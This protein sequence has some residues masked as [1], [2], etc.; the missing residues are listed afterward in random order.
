MAGRRL[1]WL[2]VTLLAVFFLWLSF[3]NVN[4]SEL[5]RQLRYANPWLLL[6]FVAM[7]PINLLLRSWRWQSLLDPVYPRLPLGELFSATAI[8]YMAMV[9]PGRVGE[10][11]RPALINRRLG[12]SFAPVLATVGVERV[13]LD[14]LAVLIAGAVAMMLPLQW[15][16]LD[17]ATDPEWLTRLRLFGGAVLGMGLMALLA[18]HLLGRH[19]REVAKWLDK[20]ADRLNEM[21]IL[22]RRGG[23]WSAMTVKRIV[24]RI[25]IVADA[26]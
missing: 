26:D 15:S 10:V 19:R 8:G 6:I 2:W 9:L 25:E 20:V 11:L 7:A 21:E 24:D 23:A 12:V 5:I 17:Q 3:R 4:L 1:T 14:L 13:V 16:G 22:T 18:V